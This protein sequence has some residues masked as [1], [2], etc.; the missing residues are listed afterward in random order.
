MP[1][2]SVKG[3]SGKDHDKFSFPKTNDDLKV[4]W[5]N[6]LN[7]QN[8]IPNKDSRV[9]DKHFTEDSFVPPHLNVT[10]KGEQ[11]NRKR[12]KPLA[13]PTLLLSSELS[14]K[15]LNDKIQNQEK[16]IEKLRAELSNKNSSG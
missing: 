5:E 10:K 7:I 3:C 15:E 8:F 14:V 13:Y 2:C 9:C 16:E 1:G 12:L 4:K 11:L 6:Q